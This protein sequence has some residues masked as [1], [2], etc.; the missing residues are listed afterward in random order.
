VGRR[1]L[2]GALLQ[3]PCISHAVGSATTHLPDGR[4]ANDL[5]NLVP[6]T[7]HMNLVG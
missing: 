5:R 3:T 7:L 1:S 6:P 2:G 4:Q